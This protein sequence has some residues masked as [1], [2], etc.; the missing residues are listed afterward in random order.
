MLTTGVDLV[1]IP[2]IERALTRYGDRFLER[3]FTPLE[4]HY[5]RR[6]P[7]ELAV[8]FAAKEA[9]SKALGVGMRILSPA[10]INWHDVETLNEKT[11]KPYLALHGR[12]ER[13]AIEQGLTIWSVS[14]SHDGG[15]AIAFVV[16]M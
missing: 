6:R 16:A 15:L 4:V 2:R 14:L 13:L 3:V 8:R 11:G 9:V 1:E 12:A 10:G 7:Q 5:S